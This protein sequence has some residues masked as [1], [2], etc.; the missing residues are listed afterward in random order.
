[1]LSLRYY[2]PCTGR[3]ESVSVSLHYKLHTVERCLRI[4]DSEVLTSL[5][6]E[7]LTKCTSDTFVI[8]MQRRNIQRYLPCLWMCFKPLLYE[9][10]RHKKSPFFPTTLL[11]NTCLPASQWRPCTVLYFA[12]TENMADGVVCVLMLLKIATREGPYQFCQIKTQSYFCCLCKFIWIFKIDDTYNNFI[13]VKHILLFSEKHFYVLFG[14]FY[15][16]RTEACSFDF[17]GHL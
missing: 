14:N 2:K 10:L 7:V 6:N 13:E 15:S 8:E 5:K 1:M 12:C 3:D 16:K 9:W 4:S 17:K 11:Q